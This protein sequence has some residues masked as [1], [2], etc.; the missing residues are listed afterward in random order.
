ML[1]SECYS[2]K[3]RKNL[4]PVA[5]NEPVRLTVLESLATRYSTVCISPRGTDIPGQGGGVGITISRHRP[6]A[7]PRGTDIPGQGGGVG[8]TYKDTDRC[9]RPSVL[10]SPVKVV[11]LLSLLESNRPYASIPVVLI[12]PVRVVVLELLL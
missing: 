4:A 2:H 12:S 7:H 3:S 6:Y 11:V 5:L 8:I 1:L 9:R 10:I